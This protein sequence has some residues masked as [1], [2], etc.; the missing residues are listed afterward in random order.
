MSNE[1]QVSPGGKPQWRGWLRRAFLIMAMLAGLG[2]L[3]LCREDLAAWLSVAEDDFVQYWAAGRLNMRGENPYDLSNLLAIERSVGLPDEEALP[4]YTPPWTLSLTTPFALLPYPVARALW[5]SAGLAIIALAGASLWLLY[6][7]HRAH[8]WL[9]LLLS[10]SFAPVLFVLRMGQIG[11]WALLGLAG[12]FVSANRQ[13]PFA[14]GMAVAFLAIKPQLLG[15]FWLVLALWTLD[16][17]CWAFLGGVAVTLAFGISA[18]VI[19]NRCVLGQYIQFMLSHP[20]GRWI[21]PTI[22]ALLRVLLDARLL[23]LQFLPAVP[24]LVWSVIYWKK[25]RR[26]WAWPREGVGLL[27]CSLIGS[28]YCCSHHLVLLLPAILQLA[29]QLQ[30][31]ALRKPRAWLVVGGYCVVDIVAILFHLA[32]VPQVWFAWL[33][34]ALAFVF[35]SG[36]RRKPSGPLGGPAIEQLGT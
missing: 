10:F 32:R 34:F 9:A 21:T 7:G 8:L 25:H 23:W 30:P 35:M 33:P 15:P 16:R 20:P 6:G 4:M 3:W 17:R 18:A 5:L 22:G 2:M 14:A 19:P 31:G 26:D 11:V 24:I 36:A 27:F 1:P 28:P 12:F 13:R 29:A